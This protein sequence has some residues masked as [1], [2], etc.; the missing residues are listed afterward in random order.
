M[1]LTISA[2][3]R[4]ALGKL[5]RKIRATGMI[6]AVLYGKNEAANIQVPAKAF[7]KV[8]KAAGESTL[9]NLV[10]EGGSSHKVLIHDVAKHYMKDEAIRYITSLDNQRTVDLA[11]VVLR[12]DQSYI[13]PVCKEETAARETQTVCKR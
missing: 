8:F 11:L 9:V 10:I 5:N 4:T 2:Q 12:M 3:S 7:Q 6:P 13:I 1:E